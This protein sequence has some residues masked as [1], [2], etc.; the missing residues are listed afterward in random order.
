MEILSK[1]QTTAWC[2]RHEID[3][4]DRGLPDLS[5]SSTIKFEIP[6]D[7]QQRVTLVSRETGAFCREPLF[8][9]W[10]RDWAV[11]PSG[12]RMQVS[13]RFR[14]SYGETRSLVDSPGHV[15]GR[16]EIE[17]AISYVTLAVLFLWDCYVVA[18]KGGK[19]L[20]FS[21]DEFGLKN[22]SPNSMGTK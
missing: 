16:D 6:A 8:L 10:F 2:S 5:G 14:L 9:V 22:F 21:H 4:N 1:E 12:Q 19:L 7:A 13:D 3:L 11:W 18:P 17:D 15:F 20:F